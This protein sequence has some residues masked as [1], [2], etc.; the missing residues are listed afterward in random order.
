[1]T[2]TG[3]LLLL[4]SS[5]ATISVATDV[6]SSFIWDAAAL[7]GYCTTTG[8]LAYRSPA[9]SVYRL[10]NG[11]ASPPLGSTMCATDRL[12]ISLCADQPALTQCKK[13]VAAA[14]QQGYRNTHGTGCRMDVRSVWGTRARPELWVALGRPGLGIAA[15]ADS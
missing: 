6:C 12:F 11:N 14:G 8:A 5:W 2:G 15:A 4:L 7:S 10:C 13:W 3:G 1:M 9:C